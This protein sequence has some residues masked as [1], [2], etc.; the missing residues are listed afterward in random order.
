[1]A[2]KHYNP[3][4]L[5]PIID[6]IVAVALFAGTAALWYNTRGQEQVIAAREGLDAIRQ[7]QAN[8]LAVRSLEIDDYGQQLVDVQND[9]ESKKQYVAFLDQRIEDE[10]AKIKDGRAKDRRYTD[11]LLELRDDIRLATDEMRGNEAGVTEEE[12][13]ITRRQSEIDSLQAEVLTREREIS[14]LENQTAEALAI[15]RHDP[16]SIFPVKAG[17][18]AA[19]EVNDENTRFVVGLSHDVFSLRNLRLGVQ[20]VLGLSS[21]ENSSLKEGGV[22]L[23]IPLIFRRASIEVGAGLSGQKQGALDTEYDPYL[24]GHFRLAPIRRE[25][26]FLLGGPHLTAETVGFRLGVG[27]GRR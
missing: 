24:S 21:D 3:S 5:M 10:T 1:M 26:F 12:D 18:L 7:E 16:I 14:D 13:R 2:M 25:R 11:V 6:I 4:L 19:Y 23:N 20:G 17:F 8:E 22:Y 27:I 15:R 9:H